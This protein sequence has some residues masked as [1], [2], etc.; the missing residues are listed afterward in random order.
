MGMKRTT[1]RTRIRLKD[2]ATDEK[3]LIE[4]AIRGEGQAFDQLVRD[5]YGRVHA[6]AFRLLGNHEDAEDLAQECFVRAHKGLESYRGDAGFSSWL[7]RILVHLA[8][9]RYRQRGRRPDTQSLSETLGPV[10][11]RRSTHEPVHEL[12]QREL[13][14]LLAEA[15][16][17][18]PDHLR[19]ALVLRTREGLSYAEIAD[20]SGVT[21]ATARTQVMKARRALMRSLEPYLEC[22]GS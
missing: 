18:L 2:L 11:D 14:L 5:H 3:R 1:R 22:R 9:D 6:T 17:R 13:S 21:P 20:S 19:V 10:V 12:K 16:G 4:R 7:R 15:V 8:R